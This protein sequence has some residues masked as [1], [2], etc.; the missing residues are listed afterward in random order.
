MKPHWFEALRD[1]ET[2]PH[3]ISQIE[4][5]E[6]HISWVVLTGEWAYKLKKPV[7]FGFVDFS[8][9]ALRHA[10]CLEELRL[11]RRTAP[12]LYD[13]VISLNMTASRPRFGGE[14]PVLEHAVRM[15][16]FDQSDLLDRRL[17]E[18][19]PAEEM[20]D[21]LGHH[22]AQLH[23]SAAT[24]ENQMIYGQPQEIRQA[25]QPCLDSLDQSAIDDSKSSDLNVERSVATTDSLESSITKMK[26][27]HAELTN[28]FQREWA[29]LDS[30]FLRRK[31]D[32]HV[33]E[34]HGDLH[35][36]NI[37]V[38]QG[39]PVLFD[40]LEFNPNLRWIDVVS[41][42]AFLFMDLQS[43][44][45]DR[46]AWRLLNVWLTDTGDFRGLEVLRHYVIYRALV[47]PK[48]A[49][50]RLSQV[51]PQDASGSDLLQQVWAY[52]ELS[53]QL[54][55]PPVPFLILMH[56]VSGSGKSFLAAQLA[57]TLGAIH[58]R[59]DVERKRMFADSP[60]ASSSQLRPEFYSLRYNER[61]YRK[62]HAIARLAL[63]NG[64]PVIVDATFL[65]RDHRKPFIAMAK[66]L[67]ISTHIIACRAPL[68][69][70]RQR[71]SD[72][73][74]AGR[75]ASDADV[76]VLELQLDN[77]EPFDQHE[78]ALVVEA[79]ESRDLPSQ[80]QFLQQ[81]VASPGQSK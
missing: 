35:A 73:Q 11:N 60:V 53:R 32:G 12:E 37:V 54:I 51:T 56:G 74:S 33:R 52:A 58:I 34:C 8:T 21:H 13:A 3:P 65:C 50:L 72:R 69:T 68:S 61:T 80:I 18:S 2:Y 7:N 6:T 23:T 75:D 81:L 26:D 24:A 70:L 41:D 15:R 64:Y 5:H 30:T 67:G 36:G 27:L 19:R 16:Q 28:W 76:S 38:Y 55:H 59:S 77:T 78:S 17:D 29:R 9:L 71:L 44:R 45:A 42:I 49:L 31:R 57:E 14:G 62:L 39:K 47:R 66:A 79:N 63:R 25:V 10:A 46:F 1:P 4:F 43:R 40:C 22:I 48:V 20:I